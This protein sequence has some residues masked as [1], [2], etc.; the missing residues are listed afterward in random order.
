MKADSA[1]G[2]H[3]AHMFSCYLLIAAK[4]GGGPL[5]MQLVSRAADAASD[6]CRVGPG[7]GRFRRTESP[8]QAPI[9]A[10]VITPDPHAGWDPG[11]ARGH[12]P[13]RPEAGPRACA[14]R[15]S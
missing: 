2:D 13:P 14:C 15:V 8:V 12:R 9:T 5:G 7:S 10:P 4:H 11:P 3:L 6:P 1:A